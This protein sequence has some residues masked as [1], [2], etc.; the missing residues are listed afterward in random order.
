VSLVPHPARSAGS[1]QAV[2]P[3]RAGFRSPSLR[4][5]SQR[6]IPPGP[7]AHRRPFRPTSAASPAA[8]HLALRSRSAV[9]RHPPACS[10]SSPAVCPPPAVS[11]RRAAG[12]LCRSARP[13]ARSELSPA[14]LWRRIPPA[15]WLTAGRSA[16]PRPPR[17]PRPARPIAPA[18][19]FRRASPSSTSR[20][21]ASRCRAARCRAAR[22]RAARGPSRVAASRVARRAWPIAPRFAVPPFPV[23][24]P[25]P[26]PALPNLALL[27]SPPSFSFPSHQHESRFARDVR[28]QSGFRCV[29]DQERG[30]PRP[31]SPPARP[32]YA[33][34][35][36]CGAGTPGRASGN[37]EVTT[38]PPSR[39]GSA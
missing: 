4:S 37:R 6:R 13:P 15:R 5:T 28:K 33:C 21:R 27:A 34:W 3:R 7:P 12:S 31:A 24:L 23:A 30:V 25:P 35:G 16:P 18:S 39:L 1:P 14:V 11:P 10:A 17:P 22:G 19:P 20:C 2:P 26:R 38:N 8:G 9:P 36:A 29:A 32:S